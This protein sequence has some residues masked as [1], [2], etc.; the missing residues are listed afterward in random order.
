[1]LSADDAR[2][3][4]LRPP[5][6]RVDP[7]RAHGHVVERERRA[8][9]VVE[10]ALTVFLAGSE[11]PFTCTFCD[12]WRYTTDEPTPRGALVRQLEAVLDDVAVR[13]ERLKLYNASNF[14]DA[15]AV[16]VDDWAELASLSRQFGGVT[17]ESHA[18]M[19]GARTLEFSRMLDG[20]RLEVAIGLETIHPAAMEQLN[21]RLS[22]TRFD[23]AAGFLADH[24]IDLRVFV[25]LNAPYT[26]RDEA[27]EW[28]VRTVKYAAQRGASVISIIPV[29]GGNG[30]IE[31]LQSRGL[32]TP[33][34]LAGLE[35]ALDACLDLSPIV[36]TADLWDAE[37]IATCSECAATRV[38]RLGRINL[39]GRAEPRVACSACDGR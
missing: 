8:G 20:A 18:S 38:A 26:P 33:P 24:G 6:P 32:F 21:K 9:G 14:F 3:R 10:Q 1:M 11:C 12:L 39:T 22:L 25:L 29:R 37:R 27:V 19:V 34:T 2:I 4:A 31:R 5:K 28:A 7:W 15:R 30:E 13:A 16:P 17:V 35:A 36:V 23:V